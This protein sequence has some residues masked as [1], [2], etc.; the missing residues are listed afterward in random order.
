MLTGAELNAMLRTLTGKNVLSV[1]L[2]AREHDPAMR[3]AWR[4]R[5]ATALREVRSSLDASERSEFDQA[6]TLMRRELADTSRLDVAPAWAAFATTDGVHHATPLPARTDTAVEWRDGPV[7]TPYL[8]AQ[9]QWSPVIVAVVDS[10]AATLYRY[11]LGTIERI[12]EIRALPTP[13]PAGGKAMQAIPRGTARPAPRAA[14]AT[15]AAHRR[16][17]SAF[18]RL[19]DQLCDQLTRRVGDDGWIVIGGSAPWA[20]AAFLGLPSH[21]ASR[22]ALSDSLTSTSTLEEIAGDAKRRASALRARRGM[23]VVNALI[24]QA[25]SG[26]RAAAGVPA[27]QRSLLTGAVDLLVMSPAFSTEQRGL[28]E[29]MLRDALTRG[30]RVEILSSVAADRLQQFAEGIAARLRYPMD[31]HDPTRS[32]HAERNHDKGRAA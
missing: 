3:G 25:G 16:R 14:L 8:R 24:E 26:G 9:K 29:D 5:F 12:D 6:A 30:A 7:V 27:V 28:A 2:D 15:E 22:A 18:E 13:N 4:T 20:R 11:E 10:R 32:H 23:G 19:T 21:L 31:G 1:Y 17:N